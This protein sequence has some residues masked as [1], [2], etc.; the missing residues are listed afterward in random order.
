MDVMDGMDVVTGVVTES[1]VSVADNREA[2]GAAART[3][4]KITSTSAPA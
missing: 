3:Y 2:S 4:K 1:L